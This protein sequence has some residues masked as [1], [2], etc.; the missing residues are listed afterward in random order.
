MERPVWETKRNGWTSLLPSAQSMGSGSHSPKRGLRN[1]V[2]APSAEDSIS[3]PYRPD[4]DVIRCTLISY[5]PSN[6]LSRATIATLSTHFSRPP[7]SNDNGRSY[8]WPTLLEDPPITYQSITQSDCRVE[9]VGNVVHTQLSRSLSS[10][11]PKPINDGKR[12]RLS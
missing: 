12:G 4:P 10:P 7:A 8:D 11:N 3:F 1:L 6:P 5:R 9:Q 2:S